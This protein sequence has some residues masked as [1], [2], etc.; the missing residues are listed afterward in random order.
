MKHV[1][2]CGLRLR[3][4]LVTIACA[5]AA[6]ISASP[7]LATS[8]PAAPPTGTV[9]PSTTDDWSGAPIFGAAAPED[10]GSLT[11][12]DIGGFECSVH[13][14][15]PSVNGTLETVVTLDSTTFT[16]TTQVAMVVW[17]CVTPTLGL[18]VCTMVNLTQNIITPPT[19][20]RLQ[21]TYPVTT[22]DPNGAVT[23]SVRVVPT[24]V[25]VPVGYTACT[26]YA[27]ADLNNGVHPCN[28]DTSVLPPPTPQPIPA[29]TFLACTP[30]ATGNRRFLGSGYITDSNGNK[31]EQAEISVRQRA[32]KPKSPQ[33]QINHR[34]LPTKRKFHSKKLACISFHDATKTVEVTGIGWIKID[35]GGKPTKV[36]FRARFQ[37][38]G[39]KTTGDNY[40]IDTLPFFRNDPST[41]SDDT[42]GAVGVAPES[43]GGTINKGDFRYRIDERGD[44]C[45]YNQ[46]DNDRTYDKDDDYNWTR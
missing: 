15:T 14:T 9:S 43:H 28:F 27:P 22:T 37:D 8:I 40:T 3:A 46:Y 34:F 2:F 1:S 6:L 11:D 42:C 17:R 32:E 35:G 7:A 44:D 26:G 41:T 31:L 20:P 29:A 5:A 33:G 39:Q 24:D 19:L 16:E 45:E 25:F 38:S 18:Q 12:A 13:E 30:D 23:Y 21:L 10:C 36:C 4:L